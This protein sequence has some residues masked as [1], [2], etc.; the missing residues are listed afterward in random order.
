[1]DLFQTAQAKIAES[2]DP[3]SHVTSS[4]ATVK[5]DKT[6][7]EKQKYWADSRKKYLR[8][9]EAQQKASAESVKSAQ[10][11][12]GSVKSNKQSSFNTTSMI[13]RLFNWIKMNV[14]MTIIIVIGAFLVIRFIIKRK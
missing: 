5:S 14:I 4:S 7:A 13:S 2:G 9:M 3:I 6:F 1:M 11:S 8:D 10:S 12:A